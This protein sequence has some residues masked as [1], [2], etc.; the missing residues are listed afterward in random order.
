MAADVYQGSFN[1]KAMDRQILAQRLAWCA[2]A[3][4]Y[5]LDCEPDC[6]AHN[7]EAYRQTIYNA[8][9]WRTNA[10]ITFPGRG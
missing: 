2:L 7:R 9:W 5:V 3:R 8:R 10:R 6:R 1:V 4:Q